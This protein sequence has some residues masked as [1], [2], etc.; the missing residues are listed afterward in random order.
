MKVK[1]KKDEEHWEKYTLMPD[2]FLKVENDAGQKNY[3]CWNMIKAFVTVLRRNG[4]CFDL[5]KDRLLPLLDLSICEQCSRMN[6]CPEIND[7]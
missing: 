3:L 6:A 2:G 1:K 7:N 5:E 4:G